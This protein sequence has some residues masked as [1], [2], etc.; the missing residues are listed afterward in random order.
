MTHELITTGRGGAG[1]TRAPSKEARA[2]VEAAI[3]IEGRYIKERESKK[4]AQ[5]V[6]THFYFYFLPVSH[7]P[8][9]ALF[10]FARRMCTDVIIIPSVLDTRLAEAEQETCSVPICTPMLPSRPRWP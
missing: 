10:P 6:R 2:A 3:R 5:I 9:I 4:G 1:N 7:F 8:L